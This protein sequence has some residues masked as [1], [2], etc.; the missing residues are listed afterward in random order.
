MNLQDATSAGLINSTQINELTMVS[1]NYETP[2][3][4]AA[5]SR[6]RRRNRRAAARTC[7]ASSGA[8]SV[9]NFSVNGGRNTSNNWT[10]DGADN[11]DR[12]ANLT[13]Y[14][15]PSPDSI[16]EF[17]TLRGQYSAQYGRNAAGQVDVVTKSGTNRIHGSAYEY[18]R[19]DYFDAAG[20]LNDFLKPAFTK[21]RYNDLRFHSRW[22]GLDSHRFTTERTR[23]SGSSPRTG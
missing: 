21:Y 3:E 19:N 11:L 16:A 12:G 14:V 15:Y 6:I 22:P 5:R 13:L 9:V 20:Y 1:R 17:K 4:P 2:D 18:F 23:P 8:S 7:R 10:I